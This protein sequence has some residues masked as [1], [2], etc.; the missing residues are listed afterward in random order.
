MVAWF[1]LCRAVDAEGEVL[2]VKAKSLMCWSRPGGTSGLRLMCK[3]IN[4]YGF[5]PTSR[6]LTLGNLADN[7]KAH[8]LAR[9][10]RVK[11]WGEARVSKATMS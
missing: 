5:V 9:G 3:L 11:I 2:D 7:P 10:R 4:K 1:Y 6:Q 8:S